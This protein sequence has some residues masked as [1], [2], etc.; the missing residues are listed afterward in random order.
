MNESIRMPASLKP[1]LWA[2]LVVLL[3][4]SACGRLSGK[5]SDRSFVA[6]AD[7][8]SELAELSLRIGLGNELETVETHSS[9]QSCPDAF[10]GPTDYV[11]PVLDYRF[12]LELLELSPD[13]FV[14]EVEQL[15]RTRQL[16]ITSEEAARVTKRLGVSS[17]GFNFQ[18][19]VN[20]GSG[21]V[22]LVGSGPCVEPPE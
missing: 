18:L 14:D 1:Q 13:T 7:E 4:F 8:V 3:V 9:H 6:A 16:D 15:W 11:S 21:V 22:Y 20:R 5:E 17:D 2:V 10:G 19:T 12:P